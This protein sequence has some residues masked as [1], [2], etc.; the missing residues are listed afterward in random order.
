MNVIAVLVGLLAIA[1]WLMWRKDSGL[2]ALSVKGGT[3]TI[4]NTDSVE[5]RRVWR[6][7]GETTKL[8]IATNVRIS[9]P[10][11]EFALVK[12]A[13]YDVIPVVPILGEPLPPTKDGR[14]NSLGFFLV[15]YPSGM[16]RARWVTSWEPVVL[17][18][19]EQLLAS[20]RIVPN[21]FRPDDTE[22]L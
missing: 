9:G 4:D 20:L 11:A 2:A 5:E 13:I 18:V 8:V 10:G 22:T 3:V 7:V 16:T 19:Q 12:G 1:W 6:Y 17:T 21:Y 15:G 14:S